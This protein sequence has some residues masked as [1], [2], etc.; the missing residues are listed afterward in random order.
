L[1]EPSEVKYAAC[2]A[3]WIYSQDKIDDHLRQKARDSITS[4]GCTCGYGGSGVACR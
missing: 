2:R 1:A 4:A 3:L